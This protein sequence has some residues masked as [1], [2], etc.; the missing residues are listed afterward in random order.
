MPSLPRRVLP[1]LLVVAIFLLPPAFG[2]ANGPLGITSSLAQDDPLQATTRTVNVELILDASGSMAEVLPDGE[3]RMAAAKRILRGVIEGLPERA[4]VNVGLRVYGHLG[5]NTQAGKAVSCRSSDLLVPVAGLDKASLIAQVEAI[6]P[7][8]WTPIAYSLEQ[9]AADFQPGGES[10]TNAIVLV[11]DGEE[12][13][14]PPQQSCDAASA[15]R[16]AGIAV[17]THVVGFALTPQQTEQVSCIAEQGGGQL[18]GANNAQQLGSA[19][20]SAMAA[21]GVTGTPLPLTPVAAAPPLADIR[22][23][24]YHQ[25]TQWTTAVNDRSEESPLLSD[26]GQRIAFARAPGAVDD[27]ANPNRIFVMNADGSGEREVDAYP[28]LCGCGSL[29]DLSADGSRIVSMDGVQLRVA[30]VNGGGGRELLALDSGELN[31]VR[32]SGDGSTIVFRIYRD[33]TLRGTSPSEPI[34]RG[35]YAINPDGSGLRQLVGPDDMATLLGVTPE[36]AGFFGASSGVDVSANGAQIVFALFVPTLAGGGSGEG[37]FA[38]TFDGSGLRRLGEASNVTAAAISGDGT[39]VACVTFDGATRVQEASVLAVD[40][41]GQRTLTDST[42]RHPGTGANLP[43]GERIQLSF[44]GS[45]LLLGSTGILYDT[46]S[47]QA[48]ALGVG[49]P[50]GP[51]DPAPLVIDGLYRATMDAGATRALYLFQPVGQPYELVRLDLNPADLG[52]APTVT[53]ASVSPSFVLT[54]SRSTATVSA[55]VSGNGGLWVSNRVL[56]EGLPDDNT[57]TSQLADDGATGG[58][59]TAQDGLFTSDGIYTDCCA[60]VGPRTVRIKAETQARDGLQHATAVDVTPFAVT[61]TP[62]EGG[63]PPATMPPPTLPPSPTAVPPTATAV[64]PSPTSVPPTATAEPTAAPIATGECRWTGTWSTSYGTMRLTQSD[65]TVSGDYEHDQGQIRGTVSDQVLSGTWDE[66]PSRQPPSD[67]GEIEFTMADDCQ[68]FTGRWRYDS[69]G[70]WQLGWSGQLVE[71]TEPTATP[72]PPTVT[73]VP[74]PTATVIPPTPIPPSTVTAAQTP[75]GPGTGNT[76]NCEE[77]AAAQAT[78]TT[79]ATRIAELEGGNPPTPPPVTTPEVFSSPTPTDTTPATATTGPGTGDETPPATDFITPDPAECTVTPRTVES[80]AAVVT[81]PD[82][83]AVDALAA[84]RID[85][86]LTVPEGAPADAATTAAVVA[87][88]RLMTACFN[89]GNELA[90]YALWTDDALRQIAVEPPTGEPTPVPVGEYSAF[91]V[92]EV[93]LLPDGQVVTVVEERNSLSA[94]TLVQVLGRLGDRYI[95]AD[96]VDVVAA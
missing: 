82:P 92:S 46:A 13:C 62:L 48:L 17:T 34:Q 4:G 96:T 76:C 64:P 90:A 44:D 91:R 39:R 66:A 87:S 14:D 16:Q 1:L 49:T 6:Q 33:T 61:D 74:P 51:G 63:P 54:E 28:P 19:L 65:D 11:T 20:S 68:S 41:S 29:I 31:A 45:R 55:R 79:Q 23:L 35:I 43:S 26:D 60:V 30:D 3:T 24:A 95:V 77:L 71:G 27:P 89:A 21:T 9:A 7:T 12:T 57:Y 2:P 93:R 84:A 72:V 88:Y 18:F 50:G 40:G 75:T 81:T 15:L 53:D 47:G 73:P 10:I 32:I 36:Q 78:I 8:G 58:D 85:A 80:L 59:A 69:S 83:A 86:T 52:G 22:T 5:D 67:A 37:L 42:T 94:T 38:V 56:R 25:L 70:E